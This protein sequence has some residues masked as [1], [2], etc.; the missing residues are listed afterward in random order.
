MWWD[1]CKSIFKMLKAELNTI[2]PTP[3]SLLCLH[4]EKYPIIQYSKTGLTQ[5]QLFL[6][7]CMCQARWLSGLRYMCR[8]SLFMFCRSLFALFLLAVVLSVLLRYTDSDYLPLVS[9]NSSYVSTI[10]LLDF[11]AYQ[12]VWYLF[13][14]IAIH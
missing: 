13:S 2:T 7:K 12:T 3:H 8:F 14:F 4:N 10:F 9:S 5:P 1:R 11:K 6:L